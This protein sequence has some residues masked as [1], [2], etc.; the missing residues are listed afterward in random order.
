VRKRWVKQAAEHGY[1]AAIHEFV[2][3]CEDPKDTEKRL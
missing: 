3:D 1:V 2:W